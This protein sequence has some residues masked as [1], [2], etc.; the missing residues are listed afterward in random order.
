MNHCA[1]GR[2]ENAAVRRRIVFLAGLQSLDLGP[3]TF[4][5]P[6]KKKKKAGYARRRVAQPQSDWA[7]AKPF[8][9]QSQSET[10]ATSKQSA[11]WLQGKKLTPET[12]VASPLWL[13]ITRGYRRLYATD[14]GLRQQNMA[15]GPSLK[16]LCLVG[17]LGIGAA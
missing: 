8:W 2:C 4:R 15:T 17:L 12:A 3:G 6:R 13:E 5:T 14:I 1:F 9:V 11:P 7:S 10:V 16:T